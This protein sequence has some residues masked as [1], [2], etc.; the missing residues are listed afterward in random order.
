MQNTRRAKNTYVTRLF[1]KSL[2]FLLTNFV[3]KVKT[4]RFSTYTFALCKYPF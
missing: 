2:R 1:E 3:K 4:V